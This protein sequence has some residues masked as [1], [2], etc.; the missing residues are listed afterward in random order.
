MIFNSVEYLLY[1]PIVAVLYFLLPQ[2]A[3][4][5]W[6]LAA[7][8]YFYM[9]WNAGYGLLLAGS[10]T[11]TYVAA[12]CMERCRLQKNEK[13]VKAA[14]LASLFLNLG[15]LAWFKY[16]GF[17]GQNVNLVLGLF[18]KGPVTIP[19]ILLPVGISFYIF[20]ALGYT[21][22]VYFQKTKAE[23]NFFTYALFVSFFPQLV[24]GPIERSTNLLPQFYEEHVFEVQRIKRGLLMMLWGLF[25]KMVIADRLSLIITGVYSD[26]LAYNGLE[27]FWLPRFSA[28]RSIAILRGILILPSA[29][30][31]FWDFA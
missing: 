20:Q 12:L 10:I 11:I 9:S 23:K 8:F 22:D 7:S 25:M 5:Y 19:D 3:K 29:V 4:N 6:L 18:G 14:M 1:F 28:F 2:K 17:L 13:G 31:A 30:P 15:A 24:A 27:L 26:Y 16:L 21:L